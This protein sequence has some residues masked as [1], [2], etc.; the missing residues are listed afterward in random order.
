MIEFMVDN[1]N[2]NVWDIGQIVTDI[3]WKTTRQ[4]KPASLD[5]TIVNDGLAQSTTFAVNNGDIVRFRK[6][7][8][9][10]FYGYVFS[11][12]WGADGQM[13]LLAYD[14]LRYLS[15]K[16]TYRFTN[17]RVEDIIRKI[18]KDYQLKVGQLA[19]TGHTIPA[20]LEAD[21]KLIDMISKALDATLMA[22]KQYYMFY[23]HFGAL[24]L[25]NIN[26]M[27]L[28]FAVGEESLMTDFS[29]KT[30]I[31]NETYNR[32]KVVRDNKETGK[33]DVY[34]HKDGQSIAKWGLLQLYE[35]ADE[36]M[37]PAQLNQL[38]S[39]LLALKNREEQTLSIDAIGDAR[40]RAGYTIYVN[41]PGEGLKPY[42]IDECSH[43][44]S[45]GA[46]TMSLKMKVV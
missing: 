33:R 38:A 2:G 34:I 18:A 6:D 37:N 12:E 9:N 19:N 25:K 4:A 43:S 11:K 13:K 24:T 8:Q 35:V 36:N 17:T 46:H 42:L 10:L 29:Y 21:T 20:L 14:Q 30:S 16:D 40:V 39:N 31:D 41:L 32:I 5:F 23:D 26:E 15:N 27:R 22:T 7:G 1:K 45:G 3:T 44:L 28:N